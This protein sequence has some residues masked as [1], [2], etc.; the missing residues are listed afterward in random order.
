MEGIPYNS[1]GDRYLVPIAGGYGSPRVI[2]MQ[3]LGT[4]AGARAYLG[5]LLAPPLQ[6]NSSSHG[7]VLRKGALTSTEEPYRDEH[8]S[9][10]SHPHESHVAFIHW[11]RTSP[12]FRHESLVRPIPHSFFSYV[13][14]T[15]GPNTQEM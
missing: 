6:M 3:T 12:S 13:P 1:M 15:V 4:D 7:I 9:F 2:P 10:P 11:N 14:I 5:S 8:I